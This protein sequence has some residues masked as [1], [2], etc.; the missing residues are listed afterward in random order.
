MID[1]VVVAMFFVLLALCYSVY[2][3]KYRRMYDRHKVIQVTLA[4]TLLVVLVLFEIDVHFIDN[5]MERADASPYFDAE[6]K[7]GLVV[8][9]LG[10]HLIFATTTFALWLVIV[11]RALADFPSPPRPSS[12]SRFHKRWG[13][14]AAIDMVLTTFS[15]WLFYWLAFV[16]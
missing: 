10:T 1:L 3:V 6:T 14:I 7:S 9:S 16:A 13:I 5:W 8:Y 2:S 4:A 11:V 12:H 15:G